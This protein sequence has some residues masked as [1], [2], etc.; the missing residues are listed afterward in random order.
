MIAW[1]LCDLGAA[2]RLQG[3]NGAAAA[4]YEESLAI[5]RGL[6]KK[7]GIVNSL[8]GLAHVARA[9]GSPRRRGR[10]SRKRL[11]DRAR[12]RTL[13]WQ[14]GHLLLE[15]G[16]T[17]QPAPATRRAWRCGASEGDAPSHIA[18]ALLEAGHAAW[19]QGEPAVTQSH[20]REALAL[21]QEG[22]DKAS[23]LAALESL[24]V[25]ALAQRVRGEADG[26]R[27]ARLLGAVEARRK[28]LGPPP[29]PWWRRPPRADGRSLCARRVSIRSSR[30]AWAEGRA[31]TLEQVMEYALAEP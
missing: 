26:E 1:A 21:F 19:L 7:E 23:L 3:D 20:A 12:E 13:A 22:E 4:L 9:L 17:R 25:A 16:T 30:P 18:W 6:G 10:S 28:A 5:Y 8:L 29:P 2:A 14:L 24:A 31:M 11:R 27:A 15:M